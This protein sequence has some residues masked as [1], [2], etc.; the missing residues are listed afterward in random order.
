MRKRELLPRHHCIIF[1][2]EYL[3]LNPARNLCH[4]NQVW[5]KLQLAIHLLLLIIFHLYPFSPLLPP[6]VS[7]FS[8]LFIRWQT[9]YASCC[10]ILLY[11]LSYCTI[12]FKIFSCFLCLFFMYYLCEKYYK[13]ITV[14]YYIFDCVNWVPRLT[15]DFRTNWTHGC[16]LGM[17]FICM[18]R[19]CCIFPF[20]SYKQI[21]C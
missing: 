4:Q 17:E 21:L 2:K 19:T 12:R 8:C 14:Q 11:F 18:Y 1:S 3:E 7:N 13:L 10:T 9:L 6:Q 16:A 15:L 20:L 5:V